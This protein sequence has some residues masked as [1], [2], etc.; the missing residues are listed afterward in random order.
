MLISFCLRTGLCG[1]AQISVVQ[2][3]ESYNRLPG[4]ALSTQGGFYK[5]MYM[6]GRGSGGGGGGGG[7]GCINFATHPSRVVLCYMYIELAIAT[8]EGMCVD[9]CHQS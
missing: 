2:R 5:Y 6:K 4:A 8:G 9:Q 7:A 3:R 1:Q